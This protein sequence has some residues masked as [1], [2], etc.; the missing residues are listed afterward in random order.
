MTA[1]WLDMDAAADHLGVSRRWLER[2]VAE[3]SVPHHRLGRLVRFT[4]SDLADI[5][6]GAAQTPMNV[7]RLRRAASP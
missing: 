6:R 7:T 2:R 3:R 4:P 1:R 5:E